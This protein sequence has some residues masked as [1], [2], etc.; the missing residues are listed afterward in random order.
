MFLKRMQGGGNYTRQGRLRR[1]ERGCRRTESLPRVLDGGQ[2]TSL[3]CFLLFNVYQELGE[4][5][6]GDC[7]GR[8]GHKEFELLQGGLNAQALA[9]RGARLP[10][11]LCP[12][13]HRALWGGRRSPAAPP[14][15]WPGAKRAPRPLAAIPP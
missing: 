5:G 9:R 15:A 12:R 3:F 2:S 7:E 8:S 4:Q 14:A 6:G 10:G 11:R 1:V 13:A